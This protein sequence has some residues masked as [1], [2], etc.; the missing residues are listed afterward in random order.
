MLY[1]P[2]SSNEPSLR[3]LNAPGSDFAATFGAQINDLIAR[4]TNYAIFDAAPQQFYDLKLLNMTPS[5]PCGSDEF[6]YKEMNYQREAIGIVSGASG[7]SFPNTQE[8]EISNIDSITTQTIVVYPDNSKG[9]VVNVDTSTNKITVSPLNGGDLPAV[10]AAD[11]L[12]NQSPVEADGASDFAQA[13]RASTITRT[14]YIQLFSKSIKYGEVE[15]F[16]LQNKQMYN[17]L[18]NE[19]RAM[20][21]QS[22]IDISNVF[23]NGEKGEAVL[24]N[25]DRAK[26]T[27][28]VIPWMNIA[29]SPIVEATSSN[30]TKGLE[31]LA[32]NTEYGDYGHT[33]FFFAT[34]RIILKISKA[35]KDAK[36]RYN[37]NDKVAKLGLE[38]INIGSTNI[39]LVPFK[40]LEDEASFPRSF[41][42]QG[43][44]LDLMNIKMRQMWD[45]RMGETDDHRA[46]GQR[47]RSKEFW[48]DH[49]F[50][51]EM[52]NPLASGFLKLVS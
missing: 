3:G 38:S 13:F 48:V 6:D 14:N 24:P 42:N 4:E 8:I 19:K 40:R 27:R 31:D 21:Q 12:A 46:N 9:S 34:P 29:G 5:L 23:W 50:G 39:V 10:T 47:K 15:L 44:L 32:L 35:Y 7:V 1:K 28:G 49:N 41:A 45:E 51:V 36:T 20:F 18:E 17:F 11:V 30:L 26:T 22:R 33:R 43:I 37:P 2:G 16:K 52:N 25:G